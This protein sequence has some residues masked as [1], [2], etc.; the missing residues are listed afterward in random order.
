MLC[1]LNM[2][3]CIAH[4]DSECHILRVGT[5]TDKHLLIHCCQ[6][7]YLEFHVIFV[8]LIGKDVESKIFCFLTV[9]S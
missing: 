2:S 8:I 9:T 1:E 4:L 7:Y 6:V 5:N 3:I